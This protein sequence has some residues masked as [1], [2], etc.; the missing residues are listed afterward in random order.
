MKVEERFLQYIQIDTP[1]D[2]N[3]DAVM[4]SSP[5]QKFFA[6][7]L[8]DELISLGVSNVE[9]DENGYVYGEI[10]A[11]TSAKYAIGFIA[12]MD[13]VSFPKATGIKPQITK[14]Y[15]GGDITLLTNDKIYAA[16]C[17]AL[18]NY[19]GMDI[20][21]SNGSTIL[22]ADDKAGVAEI[23]T[24]AE[25]VLS[26]KEIKHGKI[27]IAFTPDEE[28][29]NGAARFDV[30][31]FGCDFAY[32]VDG[33]EIGELS[34]E[35]FNGAAFKVQIM[36]TNIH[37]GSAKGKMV[38]AVVIINEIISALPAAERPET[39]EGREG[40]F[41]VN[42]IKA[43]VEKG[44]MHGIIRDHDMQAFK[45]RKAYLEG[46]LKDIS[47]K[48]PGRITYSL[49]D[50]YYNCGE[51]IAPHMHLVDN[52]KAAM[53]ANGITP[54]IFPIRG[55]TDGSG[56]SYKGLPC[57]NLSTGGHNAHSVKEFVPVQCMEKMVRVLLDIISSYAKV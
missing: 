55:G 33:E 4:P 20:I 25:Y 16:E 12:H 24:M 3:N 42:D 46:V 7:A 41:F 51:M 19:K 39:T 2:A 27:G 43:D 15:D 38:N 28:I 26:H 30:Q 17:P 53:E 35:T 8:A 44:E 56:L 49:K 52:A 1:S 5:C 22:G 37:P 11:N 10:P 48:Y 23:M 34:Y 45:K 14:N 47:A 13:T 21:T 29:G 9:T 57:P 31:R 6:H 50:E 40:Y 36:G 54:I 32:T 18:E